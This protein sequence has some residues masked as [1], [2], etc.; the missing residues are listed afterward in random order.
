MLLLSVLET[1]PLLGE[2]FQLY[3]V[4]KNEKYGYIDEN[5]KLVIEPAYDYA[6]AFSDGIGLVKQGS[7]TFFI[8][9]EGNILFYIKGMEAGAFSDSLAAVKVN[10][11][12]GYIDTS[13]T[14]VIEA[15]FKQAGPFCCG[16]AAVSDGENRYYIDKTGKNAFGRF[17][18][19]AYPFHNGYAVVSIRVAE[20][21][22]E[23]VPGSS[24]LRVVS[25]LRHGVIDVEGKYAV[26]PE[27]MISATEVSDSF[28][29]FRRFKAN[30]RFMEPTYAGFIDVTS[31]VVAIEP[32][33]RVTGDFS[34]GIAPASVSGEVYGIID[35][36]GD[37]ILEEKYDDIQ[38][39]HRGL[40]VFLENGKYGYLNRDGSIFHPAVFDYAGPFNGPL[41]EI[42]HGDNSGYINETGKIFWFHD[43]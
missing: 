18:V 13:G 42:K 33:F 26:A 2:E 7:Q 14:M 31:G 1:L 3:P 40:G 10:N 43:Y 27:I 23:E 19:N 8:D 11:Q 21:H 34:D 15:N 38:T 29:S 35:T 36:E 6:E 30:R 5:G 41:A 4:I 22:H 16:Y 20:D 37:F 39:F 24:G 28:L 12:W 17:F 25:G 9:H 32:K